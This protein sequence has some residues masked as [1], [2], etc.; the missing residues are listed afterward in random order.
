MV[1]CL[2]FLPVNEFRFQITVPAIF[3]GGESR[4][5]R[6]GTFFDCRDVTGAGESLLDVE[7]SPLTHAPLARQVVHGDTGLGG[8][9]K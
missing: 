7:I 4:I 3:S 9:Y 1:E 8:V 2:V 6:L 5:Y